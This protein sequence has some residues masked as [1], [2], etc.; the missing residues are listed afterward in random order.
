VGSIRLGILKAFCFGGAMI[1]E[2]V[3]VGSI[4]L[5]ILKDR[6]PVFKHPDGL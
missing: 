3:A 4:R 1:G 5:G 6:G 2:S